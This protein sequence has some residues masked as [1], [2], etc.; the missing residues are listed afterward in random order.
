MFEK[1]KNYPPQSFEC[2]I[3]FET[4]SIN[5]CENFNI[6]TLQVTELI[7]KKKIDNPNYYAPFMMFQRYKICNFKVVLN[8][9]RWFL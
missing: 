5:L 1:N 4:S 7:S 9:L 6:K 3:T 2:F 8:S